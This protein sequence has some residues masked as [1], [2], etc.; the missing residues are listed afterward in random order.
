M[1]RKTLD[2]S[3]LQKAADINDSG[4]RADCYL[5]GRHMSEAALD[6][7]VYVHAIAGGGTL[8]RMDDWTDENDA[9][10]MGMQPVGPRCATKA[11][12]ALRTMGLDPKVWIRKQP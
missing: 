2:L 12:K 3:T 9:G 8:A 4:D 6:R 11:R 5:C 1:T 10:E 7:A